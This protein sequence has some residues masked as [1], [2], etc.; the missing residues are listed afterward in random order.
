MLRLVE[1]TTNDFR[2]KSGMAGHRELLPRFPIWGWKIFPSVALPQGLKYGN[3]MATI[4]AIHN[5]FYVER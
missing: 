2:T 5:G 1:M 4:S 3:H